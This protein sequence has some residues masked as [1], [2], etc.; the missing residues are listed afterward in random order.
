[1][2]YAADEMYPNKPPNYG[3]KLFFYQTFGW[4]WDEDSNQLM[5][6]LHPPFYNSAGVEAINND[7]L[8]IAYD[9]LEEFA[10]A[11]AT[12]ELVFEESYHRAQ[13][14][15][16]AIDAI[17]HKVS[18]ELKMWLEGGPKPRRHRIMSPS[19]RPYRTRHTAREIARAGG[20][21]S[22]SGPS[23]DPTVAT[24]TRADGERVILLDDSDSD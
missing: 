22:S 8:R 14:A 21:S 10:T 9:G 13:L 3:Y 15:L 19:S 24:R 17:V 23:V 18:P 7:A 6:G 2:L 20:A 4:H 5:R 1:M 11:S 12:D 16:N